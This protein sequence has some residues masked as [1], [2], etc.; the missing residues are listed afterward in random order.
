MSETAPWPLQERLARAETSAEDDSDDSLRASMLAEK[1][2]QQRRYIAEDG[3]QAS[4]DQL[5]RDWSAYADASLDS[6][7]A[8]AL[9]E[10]GR[11][12]L[13]FA[14]G[15]I[16]YA[17]DFDV[18]ALSEGDEYFDATYWHNRLFNPTLP[19]KVQVLSFIPRLSEPG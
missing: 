4:V 5:G 12:H 7:L 9:L 16:D 13:K 2:A 10:A 11:C 17:F 15:S 19:G 1:Q 8:A 18:V 6:A 14:E 3:A